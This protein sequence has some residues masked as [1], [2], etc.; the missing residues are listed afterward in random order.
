MSRD[1]P[2]RDRSHLVNSRPLRWDWRCDAAGW[3]AALDDVLGRLE[4]SDGRIR[5]RRSA[6]RGRLRFT[7]A[8]MLLDL[9]AA[10]ADSREQWLAY[11]RNRN[12][13]GAGKLYVPEQ[14]SVTAVTTVVD[15][16][17]RS[18]LAEHRSGSFDRNANPFGGPGRGFR[19]RLKARPEL[20]E[21]LDGFGISPTDLSRSDVGPLLVLKAAANDPVGTKRLLPFQQTTETRRM[22]E[23]LKE[24]NE[25]LAGF[26]TE[27][28]AADRPPKGERSTQLT[29]IFNNGRFDHGGRFYGGWWQ[30]LSGS[31]RARLTIDGQ[32][33]VEL[34]FKALHPR[35]C[36]H[37]AGIP[38]PLDVDPYWLDRIGGDE[39][40]GAAK[41]A[42]NHLLNATPR[43]AMRAPRGVRQK[44]PKGVTY[45]ALLKQLED[46]HQPIREWFRSGRGVELQRIDSDIASSILNDLRFG[47][48]PCLPVHDSF[49]VPASAEFMLGQSMALAYSAQLSRFTDVR[50]YP[51]IAGWSSSEV[52]DRVRTVLAKADARSL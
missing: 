44:L 28:P 29:R 4:A 17:T 33:T 48:I 32:P 24:L 27:L 49:I 9:Y 12:D 16:L 13:Y 26:D 37:L 50:A 38:L 40:R 35:I 19:S 39:V 23:Q 11:S 14:A 8:A 1:D 5:A 45:A 42:F 47:G 41:T 46:Q 20:V 51:A 21:M 7:L 18:G 22:R 2:E 25:F 10:S 15:F 36:Y 43:H 3:D 6:D 34:D 31:E 30:S 52:E